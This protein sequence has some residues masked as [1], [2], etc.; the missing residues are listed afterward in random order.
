MPYAP[1]NCL[2]DSFPIIPAGGLCPSSAVLVR[3][4]VV[5][6]LSRFTKPAAGLT[7]GD[8]LAVVCKVEPGYIPKR[9]HAPQAFPLVADSQSGSAGIQL[10][11]IE[12]TVARGKA[13]ADQPVHEHGFEQVQGVSPAGMSSFPILSHRSF[14]FTFRRSYATRTEAAAPL[15]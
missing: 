5:S 13:R 9:G 10:P 4:P 15:A 8:F 3:G 7:P 12:P 11:S 14:S 6:E 1:N 2:I